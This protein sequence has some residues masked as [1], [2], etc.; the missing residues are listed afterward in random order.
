MNAWIIDREQRKK[1]DVDNQ[2]ERVYI[3]PPLEY[4]EAAD[5]T[6]EEEAAQ[7]RGV[8]IFNIGSYDEEE[9]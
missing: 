1:E 4:D 8:F 9:D 2:R 6:Q 7:E 5:E 3:E